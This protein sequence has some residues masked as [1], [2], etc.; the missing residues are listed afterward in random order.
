MPRKYLGIDIQE[1]V[2]SAVLLQSGLKTRMVEA[3]VQIPLDAGG[4]AEEALNTGMKALSEQLHP[5]GLATILSIPTERVICRNMEVPFTD[6]KK[7]RQIVPFELEPRLAF[8]VDNLII[9]FQKL[10]STGHSSRLMTVAAETAGLK[11]TVDVAA[12]HRMDPEAL[13]PGAYATG[14]WL[15]QRSDMPEDWILMDLA[16]NRCG[17]LA[18]HRRK[19][20][21]MRSFPAAQ[22]G[23]D[24]AGIIAGHVQQTLAG[25]DGIVK[26]AYL[27]ARMVISG[28]P[29][30]REALLARLSKQ[31]GTEIEPIDLFE[32]EGLKTESAAGPSGA[33]AGLNNALAC[34]LMAADGHPGALNFRQGPLSPKS[35]LLE[36]RPLLLRAGAFLAAALLLA[37]VNILVDISSLEKMAS[38]TKAQ[39]NRLFNSALPN[40]HTIVDPVHQLTIAMAD[41]KKKALAAAGSESHLPAIDL[42]YDLSTGTPAALDVRLSNL[43]AGDQ[44]VLM[45]GT[46]DSFN[47]VNEMKDHLEK[48]KAFKSVKINS[49]N[50]DQNGK[51]VRFKIKIQL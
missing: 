24:D 32:K 40:V 30:G 39:I 3:S 7:I 6:T 22:S 42:L 10:E 45:T 26:N 20:C 9:D 27:P 44:S 1:G 19:V 16:P 21:L 2:L 37:L 38:D 25:M 12:A 17:L 4:Q 13:I 18:V 8:P 34:A 29:D 50:M 11:T 47:S 23:A 36:F 15:C 49:A 41:L 48:N 31:L 33:T 14:W 51:R 28:A 43:V 5:E 46:T 35:R